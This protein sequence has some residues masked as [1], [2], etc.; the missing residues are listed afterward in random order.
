MAM[1]MLVITGQQRVHNSFTR[2]KN[3]TKKCSRRER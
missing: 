1:N 3:E 2:I